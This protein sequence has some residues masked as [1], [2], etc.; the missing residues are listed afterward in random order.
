MYGINFSKKSALFLFFL[1]NFCFV[2]LAK[3]WLISIPVTGPYTMGQSKPFTI[4]IG[5][6]LAQINEVRLILN[7]TVTGGVGYNYDTVKDNFYAYFPA[8]AP[9]AMLASGPLAGYY[10]CPEPF[11]AN[12]AFE[13]VSSATWDFLLD[14]QA[15]GNVVLSMI[16]SIPEFPIRTA[17]SGSISSA[18]IQIDAIPFNLPVIIGD[19]DQTGNINYADFAIFASAWLTMQGDP[20]YIAACD[21]STPPDNIVDVFDFAVFCSNWLAD[22]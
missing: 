11:Y 10:L 21:I 17:P 5:E 19:F 4:N 20:G 1:S 3:V 8:P 14:G 15:S 16:F 2:S 12:I 18:Q 7:G 6:P 9:D 22:D 13:P